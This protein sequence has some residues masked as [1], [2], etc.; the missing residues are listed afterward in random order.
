MLQ[1]VL[2]CTNTNNIKHQYSVLFM[3]AFRSFDHNISICSILG[4]YFVDTQ[5]WSILIINNY[6]LHIFT[7]DMRKRRATFEL[8]L[9]S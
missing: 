3:H 4:K 2:F 8:P 5:I 9:T 1:R 7:F 6:E